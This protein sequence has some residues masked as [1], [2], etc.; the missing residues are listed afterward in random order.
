MNIKSSTAT[1]DLSRQTLG[2]CAVFGSAFF[3]YLATVIIRWSAAY[4]T[5]PSAYYVFAR[6]LPPIRTSG[7]PCPWIS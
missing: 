2:L 4:V 7:S 1:P 6:L 5:I 3:F